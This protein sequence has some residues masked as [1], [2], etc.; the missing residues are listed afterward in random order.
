MTSGR[1]TISRG[2]VHQRRRGWDVVHERAIKRERNGVGLRMGSW[3]VSGPAG[4]AS[5]VSSTLPAFEGY[6]QKGIDRH[7][8]IET[9]AGL[10]TRQQHATSPGGASSGSYVIPM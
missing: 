8:V 3:Q 6:W 1:I 9:S 2:G 10:W 5:S 7:V 4:V